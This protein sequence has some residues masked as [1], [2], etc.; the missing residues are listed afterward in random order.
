MSGPA[1][2]SLSGWT[3]RNNTFEIDAN[4]DPAVGSGNRWVGNLGGWSCKAGITY[5]HNVGD[6]CG[7]SGKSISPSGSS[8]SLTAPLGWINPAAHDFHLT[9]SSPAID[10]ADPN[11]HPA[12]DRDGKS[13]GAAPDAG[14]YE[15]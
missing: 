4:L 10:A 7:G 11:D 5:R 6:T 1:A 3:V 9:A 13:R 14:A 15:R 8:A 12:T 2:G